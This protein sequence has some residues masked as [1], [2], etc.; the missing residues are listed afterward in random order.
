MKLVNPLNKLFPQKNLDNSTNGNYASPLSGY[1]FTPSFIKSNRRYGSILT[2][3]NRYG[4]NRTEPFAWFVNL[5]PEISIN[6][7]KAYLIEKDKPLSQADQMNVIQT[8]AKGS[9]KSYTNGTAENEDNLELRLS[10]MKLSDLNTAMILD[11]KDNLVI[12]SEIR[13]LLVSTSADAIDHQIERL[14]QLYKERMTGLSITSVAGV[15][16][17]LLHTLLDC[18]TSDKFEFT[19]MSDLFAGNEH[20]IRKGLNDKGGWGIGEMAVSFSHGEAFMDLDASLK[21]KAIIAAHPESTVRGYNAKYSAPSL[22]GQLLANQAAARGHKVYHIINNNFK[23]QSN[24]FDDGVFVTP[25]IE[26]MNQY[27]DM[28]KTSL[29]PLEMIGDM[30]HLTEIYNTNKN[31][32][33]EMFYLLSD[34]HIDPSTKTHLSNLLHDFYISQHLWDRQADKYP[35][36][37]HV[38]NIRNHEN[39][40]TLG[41]FI[42]SITNL[43]TF[44]KNKGTERDKDIATD[45]KATLESALDKHPEI[46]NSP[47]SVENLQQ[48]DCL[49]FY[50][51]L[52]SLISEPEVLEAQF[53]NIFDYATSSAKANDVIEIHGLEMV[54]KE[55]LELLV[56]KLKMLRRKNVRIVYIFDTIAT[57]SEKNKVSFANVFNTDGIL[58]EDFEKQFDFSILGTMNNEDVEQYQNK[59]NQKLTESLKENLKSNITYQFQIRRPRDLTSDLINADFVV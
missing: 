25:E 46:F 15:Q 47:T 48:S 55:S 31:K 9:I 45:L 32:I 11:G 16:D 23:Y 56:P 24:S 28:S 21:S 49:Q 57:N 54:S 30:N 8:K 27:I 26:L 7:V 34:R 1:K 13:I 12:D 18:P 19:W 59:I 22:W 10:A 52:S 44:S 41:T 17:K 29:N 3:R 36:R 50:L 4:T 42:A 43:V 38:L 6:G 20:T 58:Y 37:T 33:C 2:I 40:P 51:D 35:E 53:L 39:F 14:N 5:I